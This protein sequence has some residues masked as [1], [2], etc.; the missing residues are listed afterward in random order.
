MAID[1]E[2]KQQQYHEE[3]I[4]KA[5]AKA[6]V[7]EIVSQREIIT[8]EQNRLKSELTLLEMHKEEE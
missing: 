1:K 7:D 5:R 2:T 6:A 3:E 8:E 4:R